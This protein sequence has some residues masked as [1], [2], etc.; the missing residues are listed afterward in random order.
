M[1][2]VLVLD[3]DFYVGQL[4]CRYVNEVPGFR[5]LEPVRDLNAARAV[6]ATEEVDLLLADYVLPDGHGVE[7]IRETEVDAAV[8][9]AVADPRIVRSALR[10]GALTYIVKP[11]EADVLQRF[12]RRYA[13]YRR[14][15]NREKVDQSSLER[16]LRGLHDVS[17]SGTGSASGP[18]SS[19]TSRILGALESASGP[20]TALEVAE[21]V[22]TSRAT[23]QRHL[24]KL[25]ESRAVTVTLQY[26]S[27]GRPEHLYGT[28][29]GSAR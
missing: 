4:H 18:G 26:G 7:L 11:F 22:G 19:T 24:A 12:L 10:S 9:S 16:L 29:S 21:A 2:T 17:S 6:L 14:Y 28:D 3:D 13:R 8:L 5:A 25:A 15:W 20:M 23:A 1:T 27:T